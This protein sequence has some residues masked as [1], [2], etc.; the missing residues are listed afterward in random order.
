MINLTMKKNSSQNHEGS[1]SISEEES[2]SKPINLH[3]HELNIKKENSMKN[4]HDF[5]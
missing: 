5:V 3:F 1:L 2:A 4:E